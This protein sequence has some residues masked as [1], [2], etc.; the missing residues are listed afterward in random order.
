MLVR[1]RSTKKTSTV[2][3]ESASPEPEVGTR[4]E[5]GR[6]P[7]LGATA[8]ISWVVRGRSGLRTRY[9]STGTAAQRTEGAEGAGADRQTAPLAATVYS[10]ERLRCGAC[11]QMFAAPEPEGIGTEKY[12]ETVTAM[13]AQLKYGSGTPFYRLEQLEGQLWI[14]LPAATQW[15][16]VEQAAE[17][18]KP[19]AG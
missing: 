14:P 8:Q 9:W 17:F 19:G 5:N 10:L 1:P 18:I 7:A 12:D 6:R 3:E 11:G 2:P 16:I 4:P 15:E 13:I